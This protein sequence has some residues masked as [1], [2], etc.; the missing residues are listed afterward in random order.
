MAMWNPINSIFTTASTPSYL[1]CIVEQTL[2]S[3]VYCQRTPSHHTSNVTS[4]YPILGLHFLAWHQY[5][6]VLIHSIHV[7]NISQYYLIHSARK[8]PLCSGSSMHLFIPNS[9]HSWHCTKFLKHFISITFTFLLSALLHPILRTTPL[10]LF[11][12]HIEISYHLP[13][14]LYCSTHFSAPSGGS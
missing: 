10:V 4:V 12:L 3:L 2:H 5:R 11:L 1:S 7:S 8:L 14:I 9:I 13:A 6:T